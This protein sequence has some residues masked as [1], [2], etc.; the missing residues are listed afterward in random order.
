MTNEISLVTDEI[1]NAIKALHINKQE[2]RRIPGNEASVLYYELLEAF[3]D[4]KDRQWWWENFSRY[5]E[6]INIDD[7]LGFEKIS[8]IVPDNKELV[9]FMVEENKL[10]F[11]PI[12]EATPEAIQQ[13][14]GE[15]YFFEYYIIPKTKEWL[16]CENH[17]NYLIGIGQIII[18]KL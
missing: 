1:D 9:W 14:I 7:N 2:F 5:S 13:I 16:L 12:Y 15:C 3:V 6:S 17:H 4:G 8:H 10:P 18:D 11:Y